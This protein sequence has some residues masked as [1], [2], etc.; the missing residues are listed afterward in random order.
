MLEDKKVAIL[1]TFQEFIPGYSLT[2]I[3]ADQVKMLARYNHEPHL[4]VNENYTD[5]KYPSPEGA[6]IHKKMPFAHLKDYRSAQ[7][8]TPD[9]QQVIEKTVEVLSEE[10]KDINVIFTHDFIFTGWNL[11]YGIALKE[12][13]R[14]LPNTRW[15]HWIHSVPSVRSDWWE[16]KTWGKMHKIVYP[17]ETERT[18]VAEQYQGWDDDVRTIPHFKDP[19][20]WFD[21]CE[22]TNKFIDEYPNVMQADIVQILPASVDR[23]VAKRVKEVSYIF[24]HLKNDLS[25]SVCLV[26]ANQWATTRQHKENIEKYKA[27]GEKVGLT[28]G[29]DYIFTSDFGKEYEVGISKRMIRELFLLSNLFIFPTREESFGLVVPEAALS[30]CFMVL[31][32]SL[33]MQV[34][35][36]GNKAKYFDFGSHHMNFEVPGPNYWLDLAKIIFGRMNQNEALKTKTFCRQTYNMDNLYK[37]YYAPIMREMLAL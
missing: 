6:I 20:T 5:H 2:G 29:V 11:P 27:E 33:Q 12:I 37:K 32:K 22:D 16:I 19:R 17:N 4:F 26:V 10:L 30:G 14:R 15:L 31:N 8:I 13:G 1:T 21:F 24:G 34:E 3:V 23:L 28:L 36:S 18:R 35:V 25:N 7:N 9:H